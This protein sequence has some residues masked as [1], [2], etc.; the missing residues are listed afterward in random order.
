MMMR[1][2][3]RAAIPP[4]SAAMAWRDFRVA[5]QMAKNRAI[6]EIGTV[7]IE[8]RNPPRIPQDSDPLHNACAGVGM[9]R[10]ANKIA[11]LILIQLF[12]NDFFFT[13]FFGAD[14][15]I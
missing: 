2:V 5:G 15:T 10:V 3:V 13:M 7:S 4:G 12:W 9:R 11:P 6:K 8:R 1:Y 14:S